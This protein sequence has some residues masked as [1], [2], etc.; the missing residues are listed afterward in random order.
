MNLYM[1]QFLSRQNCPKI[2]LRKFTIKAV[3]CLSACMF[4]SLYKIKMMCVCLSIPKDLN[5]TIWF[6]LQRF[7]TFQK[8][9]SKLE[10]PPNHLP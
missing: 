2:C 9:K 8:L 4:Q 1:K 7:L 5:A 10:L 6:S 3:Q